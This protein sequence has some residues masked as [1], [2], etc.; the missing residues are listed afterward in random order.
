MLEFRTLVAVAALATVAL[1]APS[2]AQAAPTSVKA[3]DT[4]EAQLAW[5][6]RL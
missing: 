2:T 3:G 1:L 5:G 4:T 6:W